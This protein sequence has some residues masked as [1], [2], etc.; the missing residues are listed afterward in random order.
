MGREKRGGRRDPLDSVCWVESVERLR[1]EEV[2]CVDF[3][4]CSATKDDQ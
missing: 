1:R 3:A 4:I 2:A